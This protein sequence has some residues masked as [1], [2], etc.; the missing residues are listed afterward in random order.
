MLVSLEGSSLATLGFVY[1]ANQN[2]SVREFIS[3]HISGTIAVRSNTQCDRANDVRRPAPRPL[4]RFETFTTAIQRKPQYMKFLI[5]SE[6]H[7]TW[8]ELVREDVLSSKSFAHWQVFRLKSPAPEMPIRRI[9]RRT[10]VWTLCTR[11]RPREAAAPDLPRE[12]RSPREDK[13][14][15]RFPNRFM[16]K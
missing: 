4:P 7:R 14:S 16:N 8:V 11:V 6:S 10:S 15:P 13:K 1:A 12:R 3:T 2:K 5:E 9:P